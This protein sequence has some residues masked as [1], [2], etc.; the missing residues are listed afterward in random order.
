MKIRETEEGY[1]VEFF[2]EAKVVE[3]REEPEKE[4]WVEV[5]Y[6]EK[7]D[8]YVPARVFYGKR[9]SLNEVRKY[10][11]RGEKCL[12]RALGLRDEGQRN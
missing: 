4:W 12:R 1:I 9:Y 6:L 3:R 7:E 8:V 11:E 5:G 10:A 2:P